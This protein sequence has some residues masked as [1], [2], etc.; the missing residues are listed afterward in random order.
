MRGKRSICGGFWH[1]RLHRAPTARSDSFPLTRRVGETP[2]KAMG[3]VIEGGEFLRRAAP[4][5]SGAEGSPLSP[6]C[7]GNWLETAS[8]RRRLWEPLC[9]ANHL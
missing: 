9:L 2:V 5:C 1:V 3:K 6:H 7:P 8:G 4:L